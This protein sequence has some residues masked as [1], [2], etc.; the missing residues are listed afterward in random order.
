MGKANKLWQKLFDQHWV[1]FKNKTCLRERE[2]YNNKSNDLVQGWHLHGSMSVKSS[3]VR[4]LSSAVVKVPRNCWER[5]L[6]I[7]VIK[8]FQNDTFEKKLSLQRRKSFSTHCFLITLFL[9]KTPWHLHIIQLSP[10]LKTRESH[11]SLVWVLEFK[12]ISSCLGKVKVFPITLA[13]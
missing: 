12:I 3:I 13:W 7:A 2:T 5:T 11:F 10:I 1:K 9:N 6:D 4:C 8:Y